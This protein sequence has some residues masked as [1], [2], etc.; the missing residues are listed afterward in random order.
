MASLRYGV[1]LLPA[2]PLAAAVAAVH[3]RLAREHG[4]HAAARFMPH[5][6]LKG[7]FR[8]EAEPAELEARLAPALD[9]R[10]PVT[11]HNAG[12]V[13]L[14]PETIAL[15][16]DADPRGGRNDALHA[17]HEAVFEAVGPCV[18]PGCEFTAAEF[19]GDAFRAHLTLAMADIPP[20]RFAGLL[21]LAAQAPVGPPISEADEVA[22]F[23]FESRDWAGPWWETLTWRPVASF[24]LAHHRPP[25]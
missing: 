16:V 19:A 5:V 25:D 1:Y 23:A 18:A 13:A 6:T 21:A 3:D 24:L 17:L 22:L 20:D 2:E 15:D 9:R 12:A 11:L 7:F 10:P 14:G 4:L 8:T